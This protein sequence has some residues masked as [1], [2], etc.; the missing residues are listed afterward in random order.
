MRIGRAVHV[1]EPEEKLAGSRIVLEDADAVLGRRL[2]VRFVAFFEH[3][4]RKA[5]LRRVEVREVLAF[6]LGVARPLL[7]RIRVRVLLPWVEHIGGRRPGVGARVHVER[8]AHLRGRLFPKR[9][10]EA[11]RAIGGAIRLGDDRQRHQAKHHLV[12]A[13]QFSRSRAGRLRNGVRHATHQVLRRSRRKLR[14]DRSMG[15]VGVAG[16]AGV[17]LERVEV[18]VAV[19]IARVAVLVEVLLI[20]RKRRLRAHVRAADS[21]HRVLQVGPAQRVPRH[22][23]NVGASARLF[24]ELVRVVHRPVHLVPQARHGSRHGR[25]RSGGAVQPAN[26]A[27]R[28][29]HVACVATTEA[30]HGWVGLKVEI[31]HENCERRH[32]VAAGLWRVGKVGAN[33]EVGEVGRGRLGQKDAAE[34]AQNQVSNA[35]GNKER[36]FLKGAVLVVRHD[37][38]RARVRPPR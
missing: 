14:L 8:L 34:E 4:P 5:R 36:I 35:A 20:P 6:G 21:R 13:W 12:V 15:V 37:A 31:R 19:G 10:L 29:V 11:A 32:R 17:V 33:C 24:F 22:L 16:H 26:A 7:G 2:G 27:Q 1:G 30:A 23:A 18:P 3:V 25:R 28:R 9:V 38:P